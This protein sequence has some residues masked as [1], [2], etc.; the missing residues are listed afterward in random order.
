MECPLDKLN[1]AVKCTTLEEAIEAKADFLKDID[2]Y[3]TLTSNI[4]ILEGIVS[5]K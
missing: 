1:V 2:T 5:S 3:D 4:E